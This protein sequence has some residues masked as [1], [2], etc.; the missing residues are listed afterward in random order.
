MNWS[1][2]V[3]H[4]LSD[5]G[6]GLSCGVSGASDVLLASSHVLLSASHILGLRAADISSL[7]SSN[8]GSFRS[9]GCISALHARSRN[10]VSSLSSGCVSTANLR[11]GHSFNFER[12]IGIVNDLSE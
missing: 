12:L 11:S 9:S 5:G 10:N 6:C 7:S 4:V 2:G 1:G 3:D 8:I